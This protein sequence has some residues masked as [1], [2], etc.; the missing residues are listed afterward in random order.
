M[1]EN[2]SKVWIL[3]Q[4]NKI[5][6]SIKTDLE[7]V[8][9]KLEGYV[10]HPVCNE[11]RLSDNSEKTRINRRMDDISDDMDRIK[12]SFDS[13]L[14]QIRMWVWGILGGII[15]ELIMIIVA[16]IITSNAVGK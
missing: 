13:S 16:T 14:N 1:E 7:K 2:I 11:R 10:S 12:D 8:D 6:E 15:G 9:R 5:Y 4:F 3:E